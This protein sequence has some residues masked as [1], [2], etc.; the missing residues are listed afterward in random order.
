M[1][2]PQFAP[3]PK[4][5]TSIL[6]S[7]IKIGLV[8][9][10]GSIL[11]FNS[12][13]WEQP[14]GDKA[15]R[16]FSDLTQITRDNV[17]QLELAWQYQTG[18]AENRPELLQFSAAQATP[19]LLPEE[20][21]G[22]LITCNN[23]N[24]V[25]ALNPITGEERWRYNANIDLKSRWA[26]K[27]RGVSF[28][29]DSE[30][31]ADQA[32]ASR[33][34][35]AALDRRLISLDA[36]TGEPC[37]DFGEKGIV[38]LYDESKGKPEFTFS[39]SPAVIINSVVVVASA[40]NDFS[41][42]N[43]D[44]GTLEAL[45]ARTG[46]QRWRFTAIPTDPNS[47]V[48]DNWPANPHTVSG[49]AN[50]WAP[51]SVDEQLD[52]VYVPVGAASPDYYGAYRP[53]DNRYANS[54][55][56]LK[57]STGEVIWH[58]QTSHHDVW[59][60]DLP[61]QPLL[62]DIEKNNQTIPAVVQLT[63]QGMVFVFNRET[64][65]PLF[66]IEERPVP[67]VGYLP[68]DQLSQTQPFP[69]KPP[70]LVSHGLSPDDAWG[71]TFWDK[72]KCREQIENSR[73][74][75]IYT[76]LGLE[77]TILQPAALGGVNWGGGAVWPDKNLLLVNVNN[78]AMLAQIL[79]IEDAIK[80]AK[81]RTMEG[82]RV[83]APMGGTPYGLDMGPFV[84]PWGMPC[85]SPPWGK[86][87]AVDLS[88]GEIL[89]ESTL[90][91]VH[92]LGPVTVPFEIEWGTPNFGGPL[93]TAS[94]LVFIAATMDRRIRAFDALTGEKLWTFKLPVDATATPMTYEKNG[95][96]Y[97]IIVAGGHFFFE[98]PVG[99]YVLAFVLPEE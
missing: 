87:V 12:L 86:L 38:K 56:A 75:G 20:S 34:Y 98:R 35:M 41:G 67:Q 64:G 55:V 47:P 89:W 24:D 84:S 13:A 66:E 90:G 26:P 57:G 60:Y 76:P 28:W 88:K 39:V 62:V 94:G 81:K 80:A 33:L 14:N 85:T 25:I 77:P 8:T 48:A 23:F 53:G 30:R 61:A 82:Q 16:K 49:A 68:G 3:S 96:Q 92:E 11:P 69:I 6:A 59:D 79:P 10:F 44:L 9:I 29:R 78:T 18:D 99:D 54:L 63:K 1:T 5:T 36:L 15:G 74:D 91:S 43:T 83:I 52:M 31:P 46:K 95:R 4:T 19:I 17:D 22:H 21:G 71:L 72:G 93:V 58:F 50:A 37:E 51:L 32:C 42:A 27:C 97:V 65:E 7:V 45:D 70:P 40:I 73:N 2:R